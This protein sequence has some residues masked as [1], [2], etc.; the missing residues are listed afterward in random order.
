MEAG[1]AEALEAHSSGEDGYRLCNADMLL[2]EGEWSQRQGWTCK[3]ALDTSSISFC[4]GEYPA[5]EFLKNARCA[6]RHN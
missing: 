1:I 5:H 2:V 3:S 6:G 4:F